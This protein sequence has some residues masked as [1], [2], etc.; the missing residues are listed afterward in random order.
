MKKVREFYPE[1]VVEYENL[2]GEKL[3]ELDYKYTGKWY[4][5]IMKSENDEEHLRN[6][7]MSFTN[8]NM[9]FTNKVKPTKYT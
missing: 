6:P 3:A 5:E 8:P 2:M 1:E 9:S 4:E 7:N